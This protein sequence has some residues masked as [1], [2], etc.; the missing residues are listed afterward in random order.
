MLKL[1]EFNLLALKLKEDY[2]FNKGQLILRRQT[3]PFLVGLFQ[4]G[5]FYAEVWYDT[6]LSRVCEIIAYHEKELF[7]QYTNFIHLEQLY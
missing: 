3:Y 5:G 6:H 1:E 7:E 2:T 4:L